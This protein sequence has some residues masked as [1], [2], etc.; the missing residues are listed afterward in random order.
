[1]SSTKLVEEYFDK[2][3]GR[4]DAIYEDR[5][6]WHQRMIDGLF[7]GVVRHRLELVR[8]I[9]P[10]EGSWSVL[11]VGCG[12][13]RFAVALARAGATEVLGVDVSGS[14]VEMARRDALAAGVGERSR[15]EQADFLAFDPGRRYDSVLALGYFDYLSDPLPH[16]VQMRDLCLG[17]VFASFPKRFDF[18]VPTRIARIR[19]LGRGF[20]RF[21]SRGDVIGLLERSGFTPDRYVVVDLGRDYF[22]IARPGRR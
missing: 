8:A 6:P 10:Q 3:A 14:M 4:F 17:R 11:D 16:L 18:R 22:V 1:V 12:S 15:F 9:A 13:G 5:K 7:R 20:V 2:E 19:L 21:Y